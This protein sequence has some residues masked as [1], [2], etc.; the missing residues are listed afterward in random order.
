MSNVFF[1]VF[2]NF[3][4]SFSTGT[5]K[6][7]NVVFRSHSL[8]W[9]STTIFFRSVLMAEDS[10]MLAYHLLAL[11]SFRFHCQN[12]ISE[13]T[14]ILALVNYTYRLMLAVGHGWADIHYCGRF[15]NWIRMLAMISI[16]LESI[17]TVTVWK[18]SL[19]NI[20]ITGISFC[21]MTWIV[22]LNNFLSICISNSVDPRLV[23]FL[24]SKPIKSNF[25]LLD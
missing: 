15:F 19:P 8:I 2:V 10:G 13:Y 6:N 16:A 20:I 7:A 18:N 1:T 3:L 14:R 5:W 23:I 25:I 11:F 12:F 17:F 4:M 21:R 24:L 22:I 9:F